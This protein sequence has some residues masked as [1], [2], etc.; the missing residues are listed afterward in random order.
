MSMISK[1]TKRLNRSPVRKLRLTPAIMKLTSGWKYR[2][3]TALGRLPAAWTRQARATSE[4]LASSRP[5]NAS[6]T[7]EMP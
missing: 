4:A 1:A 6:K 7:S 3:S 2:R 5:L